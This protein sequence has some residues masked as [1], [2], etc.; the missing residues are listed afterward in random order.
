MS[1]IVAPPEV[2]ITGILIERDA[3]IRLRGPEPRDLLAACARRFSSLA[4]QSSRPGQS[5]L[6]THVV[7]GFR[8]F[9]RLPAMSAIGMTPSPSSKTELGSGTPGSLATLSLKSNGKVIDSPGA[10]VN[11][12]SPVSS[13]VLERIG[14]VVNLTKGVYRN[15][16]LKAGAV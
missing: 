6:A 14:P 11:A 8:R 2:L 4:R 10:S 12:S 15:P 7:E 1:F 5:A 3:A 9:F 13:V 16:P